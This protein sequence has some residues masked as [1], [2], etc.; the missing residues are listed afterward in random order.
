MT[1]TLTG[2][3]SITLTANAKANAQ[4]GATDLP[5]LMIEAQTHAT[6]LQRILGQVIAL[7]PSGDAN[8]STL[9][10]LLAALA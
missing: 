6:E 7:H 3:K 4:A 5:S 10:T 1:T 8:L 9:N 2:L